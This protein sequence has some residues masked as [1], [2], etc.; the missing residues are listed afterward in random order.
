MSHLVRSIKCLRLKTNLKKRLYFK[1]PKIFITPMQPGSKRAGCCRSLLPFIPRS[2]KR[3][4]PFR[5]STKSFHAFPASPYPTSL[6]SHL[7]LFLHSSIP[8]TVL[9]TN[10][11]T[12]DLQAP[13][14]YF[15]SH[16]SKHTPVF[17]C[18]TVH[19][20][21]LY[22]MVQL[23]HLL[24][25][26]LCAARNRTPDRVFRSLVTTTTTSP[27]LQNMKIQEK[28]IGIPIIYGCENLRFTSVENVDI[29][30]WKQCNEENTDR[31]P[32]DS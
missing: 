18:F 23:M 28:Q 2:I 9:L 3:S 16:T 5:L 20:N 13:P 17:H 29:G 26:T 1:K 6:P 15:L 21:S 19:F 11:L 30:L 32:P 10:N 8:W 27:S 4:F 22:I 31:V 12:A 24:D 14:C 7:P 25:R